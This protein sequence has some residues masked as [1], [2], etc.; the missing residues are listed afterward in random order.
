VLL[1]FEKSE[2]RTNE[3]KA[4]KKGR[5]QQVGQDSCH[6]E[7]VREAAVVESGQVL[8]LALCV[9]DPPQLTIPPA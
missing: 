2:I 8:P 7:S 6:Q 3:D 1:L 4:S 5:Q 9:V